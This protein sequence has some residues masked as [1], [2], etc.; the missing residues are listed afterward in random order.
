GFYRFTNRD[1]EFG[2]E[3]G[4]LGGSGSFAVMDY[5]IGNDGLVLENVRDAVVR[6]W[7]HDQ[8]EVGEIRLDAETLRNVR[9]A[10]GHLDERLADGEQVRALHFALDSVGESEVTMSFVA[11]TDLGPIRLS[12]D[13][14]REALVTGFTRRNA[15]QIRVDTPGGTGELDLLG[16][17]GASGHDVTRMQLA[18]EPQDLQ[19][20]HRDLFDISRVAFNNDDGGWLAGPNVLGYQLGGS[21]F[22]A[23]PVMSFGLQRDDVYAPGNS[24]SASGHGLAFPYGIDGFTEYT[25]NLTHV[26]AMGIAANAALGDTLNGYAFVGL[27]GSHL[28]V[29]GD[30]LTLFGVSVPGN[31]LRAPLS[32]TVHTVLS[33]RTWELGAAYSFSPAGWVGENDVI[34]IDEPNT[35]AGILHG[36]LNVGGPFWLEGAGGVGADKEF[37]IQD[38]FYSL[39]LRAQSDGAFASIGVDHSDRK[40]RDD[41]TVFRVRIGVEF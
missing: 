28:S 3:D 40:A 37:D 13:S 4:A 11:E 7:D 29:S 39:G 36:A 30:N 35:H 16:I 1:L 41:H 34:Q 23:G 25:P 6:V 2:V 5:T 31:E 9:V 26:N 20:L 19:R 10:F 21:R 24:T 15:A 8:S 12:I 18:Y 33:S 27:A 32:P 17:L 22:R 38:K 14:A